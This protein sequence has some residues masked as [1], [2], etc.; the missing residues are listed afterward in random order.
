MNKP[1]EIGTIENESDVLLLDIG[2]TYCI[3][4]MIDYGLK[5]VHAVQVYTFDQFSIQESINEVLDSIPSEK[6][7]RKVIVS[8][9]FSEALLVPRKFFSADSSFLSP[10]YNV[11]DA[12]CLYDMVGEWQMVN[13]YAIPAFLH[14][15]IIRR[16]PAAVFTH[17]YTPFVK[18]NSDSS[19]EHQL[20]VHFMNNQFRVL[21][22]MHQQI[23]LVQTYSYASP[24]DVVYYLLKIVSEFHLS[25][26]EIHLVLSGFIDEDSALFK[27]LRNYFLNI[28]FAAAATLNLPGH[29][30]PAH[31]FTSLHN[32]AACVL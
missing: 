14:D 6:L 10:L 21:L 2:E 12:K 26:E 4:S 11:H 32:L 30:H 27:E 17:V 23:H 13:A 5:S 1:F 15:E 16:Y 9:A 29:H 3:V 20:M 19:A 31:F 7:F 22:K 8:P 18:R 28:Q 25:Q 24:M